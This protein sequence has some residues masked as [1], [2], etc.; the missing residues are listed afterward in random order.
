MNYFPSLLLFS[1]SL[2]SQIE[3]GCKCGIFRRVQYVTT[4]DTQTPHPDQTPTKETVAGAIL[5]GHQRHT[6]EAAEPPTH[7]RPARDTQPDHQH[8]RQ[9]EPQRTRPAATDGGTP[10]AEPRHPDRTPANVARKPI[11]PTRQPPALKG[12]GGTETSPKATAIKA[13]RQPERQQARHKGRPHAQT[14]NHSRRDKEHQ[15]QEPRPSGRQFSASTP[16]QEARREEHTNQTRRSRKEAGQK[17]RPY[18][19]GQHHA[20]RRQGK[21]KGSG[22]QP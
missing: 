18:P 9:S 20:Q 5:K 12:S 15:P 14:V 22:G 7:T 17:P 2:L 8:K 21:R 10:E 19:Q 13:A 16:I 4:P 11:Q 6:P 1:F 3:N